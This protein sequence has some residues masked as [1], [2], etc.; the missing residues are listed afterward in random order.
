MA[1][2]SCAVVAY[3]HREVNRGSL[4]VG[5]PLPWHSGAA[6]LVGAKFVDLLNRQNDQAP[7]FFPGT[8]NSTIIRNEC[9]RGVVLQRISVALHAYVTYLSRI[10]PKLHNRTNM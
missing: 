8:T 9:D 3:T 1:D 4:E 5:E 7:D 2:L 10:N 6:H